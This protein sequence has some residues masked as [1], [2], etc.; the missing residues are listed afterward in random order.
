[1]KGEFQLKV[2][3][4]IFTDDDVHGIIEIILATKEAEVKVVDGKIVLICTIENLNDIKNKLRK[5]DDLIDFN[6]VKRV[7]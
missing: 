4:G 2:R 1:M 3:R 6:F 7:E 5:Y